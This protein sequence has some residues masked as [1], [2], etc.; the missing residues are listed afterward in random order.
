MAITYFI[1][2]FKIKLKEFIH[3]ISRRI[4]CMMHQRQI[5][6][7]FLICNSSFLVH[8]AHW[9]IIQMNNKQK[10]GLR[11]TMLTVHPGPGVW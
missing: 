4:M 3:R 9:M 8:F 6:A 10:D 7:Y 5:F 2:F 1:I 11:C